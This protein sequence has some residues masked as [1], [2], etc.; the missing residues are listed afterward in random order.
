MLDL[1]EITPEPTQEV[2]LL[3]FSRRAMATTFE[4]A[5]PFNTP[6]AHEAAY[7]ALDL[8]DELEA[9]LTVYR[10]DSEVTLMNQ[11]APETAV[12]VEPRLFQLLQECA[13]LT[14][15]SE[16]AFDVCIGSLIRVWGFLKREGCVPSP[17]ELA[18][19]RENSGF[20]HVILESQSRSV[21]YLRPKLELN[22]GSVGK[23]YALD[24]VAELLV[25]RWGITSALLHGG[26]SSV[27]ALGNPPGQPKGWGIAIRHPRNDGTILKTA[28][29]KNQGLG[30]SAATFQRF[31]YN[32]KELGHLLDPRSGWPAEGI[33]NATAIAPTARLADAW[34]TAWFVRGLK[35][36][37]ERCRTHAE[38]AAL[39]LK[40]S[41]EAESI[42]IGQP[43][44]WTDTLSLF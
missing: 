5:L 36:A 4:V 40:D 23:G 38:L 41:P 31:L 2:T 26:G 19:A 32:N 3:R 29:L 30:T 39:L 20:R 17:A 44:L 34:S 35:A 25:Q 6:N 13:Q 9:Q 16:G 43:H 1:F 7:D 15:D 42:T 27:Y 8:V 12:R 37:Q 14:Q 28:W 22:F 18:L 11:L 24:R 33:G 21:R 10:A